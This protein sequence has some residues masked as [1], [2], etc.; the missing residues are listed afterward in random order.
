MEARKRITSRRALLPSDY[1]IIET[2]GITPNDYYNFLDEV[3]F[4]TVNRG[5]EYSHIPDVRNEPVTISLVLTAVGVALSV[6]SMLLAPKPKAP[7]ERQQRSLETGDKNG[8][9]RFTPYSDFASVQELAALGT[10]VPLVYARYD[11]KGELQNSGVRVNAQLVWSHIETLR[12]SQV[13]KLLMVVSQ[14]KIKSAPDFEGIAIGDT[15][16]ENYEQARL[17]LWFNNGEGNSRIKPT[18]TYSKFGDLRGVEVFSDVFSV[19]VYDDDKTY[20][21]AFSGA[22]NPGTALQFGMFNCIPNGNRYKV[23]YEL[24]LIRDGTGEENKQGQREKREKVSETYPIGVAAYKLIGENGRTAHEVDKK[25]DRTKNCNADVGDSLLVYICDDR[26]VGGYD[27]GR[28]GSEDV[29][30][31]TKQRR[32]EADDILALGKMYRFGGSAT[33]V[34]VAEPDEILDL[35]RGGVTYYLECVEEGQVRLTGKQTKDSPFES[36]NLHD[37]SDGV[38]TT[39]LQG[40]DWVDIGI[41]STVWKRVS[42]FPN[43]NSE[44]DEETIQEYEEEGGS[45]TLGSMNTYLFRM[46]FFMIYARPIG[47]DSW[48]SLKPRGKIF[49]IKH[50]NPS[51]VFNSFRIE[52]PNTTVEDEFEIKFRSVPG[53]WVY[54]NLEGQ[55]VIILDTREDWRDDTVGTRAGTYRIWYRGY[56]EQISLVNCSN[57]EFAKGG[58]KLGEISKLK[59]D[60]SGKIPKAED[61]TC[62]TKYKG[63]DTGGRP[64]EGYDFP[65]DAHFVTTFNDRGCKVWKFCWD[66]ETIG[67][68]ESD[69]KPSDALKHKTNKKKY[70]Y[71]VGDYQETYN[72][73]KYYEIIRCDKKIKIPVTTVNGTFKIK[74]G[75]G[76]NGKVKYTR[77]ENGAWEMEL[78]D[79]GEGY[80]NGD[81]VSIDVPGP[82]PSFSVY[83]DDKDILGLNRFD[84]LADYPKYDAES[85]SNDGDPEHT[86]S[87]INEI[88][89]Y[90]VRPALYNNLAMLGLWISSSTDISSVNQIS[91]YVK[92]GIMG[93]CWTSDRGYDSINT[94]PEIVYDLL[95]NTEYGVGKAIGDTG[96][97]LPDM[98]D[99]AL[100]CKANNFWWNGVIKDPS[101]IRQWIFDQAGFIMCDFCVVGGRFSLKPSFPVWE[102]KTIHA[103]KRMQV[104]DTKPIQVSGLFTDGNTRDMKVTFLAPEERELFRAEVVF[105]DEEIN[106]FSKLRTKTVRLASKPRVGNRGGG[107][108]KPT[109]R[110]DMS[111]FCDSEKHA[112]NF[113][114]YALRLRQ[115]ITHAISFE[116]TPESCRSLSPGA[117]IR[118]ISNVT[119]YDRFNAGSISETGVCQIPRKIE[120]LDGKRIMYWKPSGLSGLREATLKLDNEYKV[121]D[122]NL[123]GS[124]FTTIS[125]DVKTSIYKVETLEYGEDGLVVVSASEAPVDSKLRLLALDWADE[126][127][128]THG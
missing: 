104:E 37:Y 19:E 11:G 67:E 114:K 32:Y 43:V 42:G 44:P 103:K 54:R 75:S 40:T 128:V 34:C 13:A 118:F 100:Y 17:K 76:N 48:E 77:W 57:P 33:F 95:T 117:F 26:H 7:E 102:N 113:A 110:F 92:Y 3:E 98:R 12:K 15:L 5:K 60:S 14:G 25:G 69:N 63:P 2:L 35:T 116:T 47:T 80:T 127:F 38:I 30:N 9:Q 115:L 27:G 101:N 73:K 62:I 81:R 82:N 55:E 94:L 51:E 58:G 24:V 126:D 61:D 112:T 28:W 8:K 1:D 6:A 99:T 107:P 123:W 91:A 23:D 120:S 31:A 93:K 83:T 20:T 4:A 119:H 84:M 89:K 106:G 88:H 49:C 125:S 65:D 39:N 85:Q 66:G 10:P 16:L 78:V 68:K 21:R 22:R 96:I 59:P 79:N 124:V 121:V 41:K 86:I 29:D 109:E 45:I 70:F 18:D 56:R 111:Q 50:N 52:L 53:N 108:E 64:G 90:D 72:G 97:N 87:Y 105:R 74:G 46:S 122:T 36:L 71:Y